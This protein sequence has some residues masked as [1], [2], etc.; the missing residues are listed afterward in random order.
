MV[1]VLSCTK[2]EEPKIPTEK[3]GFNA[4]H[5]Q[6]MIQMK[7][8]D[9]AEQQLKLE[10]QS[11]PRNN[12]A[13]VL[14]ASIY[15]QK[16]NITIRDYF[17]LNDIFSQKFERKE[18]GFLN[19]HTLNAIS[20]NKNEPALQLLKDLNEAVIDAEILQ[21]Q[22]A[23]IPLID[24]VS[25]ELV[26]QSLLILEKLDTPKDGDRLF[27]GLAKLIYFKYQWSLGNFIEV[28]GG[29]FCDQRLSSLKHRVDVFRRYVPL[30]VE[31]LSFGLRN[32]KSMR[33]M[34]DSL[35]LALGEIL[36]LIA[37]FSDLRSSVRVTVQA[38][39]VE[40]ISCDF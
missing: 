34:A 35:R 39:H 29:R 37:S 11:N 12:L 24:P 26:Y 38:L 20:Q 30:M 36:K 17:L 10:L 8:Y 15:L 1:F 2:R 21:S 6:E 19:A 3:R 25:A 28:G 16:A 23:Q 4:Q 9:L 27:R 7:E 31:D 33:A 40:K 32:G 13:R 5:I 18:M 22:L 14:W